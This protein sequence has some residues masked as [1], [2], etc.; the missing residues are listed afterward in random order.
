MRFSHPFAEESRTD[1]A[2]VSPV[3]H[4]NLFR[5]PVPVQRRRE[6]EVKTRRTAA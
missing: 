6:N 1:G 5:E 2:P 3:A 4:E